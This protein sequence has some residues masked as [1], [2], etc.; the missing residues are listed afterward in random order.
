MPEQMTCSA[1]K[2]ANP[3]THPELADPNRPLCDRHLPAQVLLTGKPQSQLDAERAERTSGPESSAAKE[4]RALDKQ[5]KHYDER[6][7]KMSKKRLR[8]G[9]RAAK[10]ARRA[11]D[12][13]DQRDK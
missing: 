1:R 8:G 11:Q 12:L 4:R 9:W 2:C 13:R 5:A 6:A 7:V 3:V 10:A